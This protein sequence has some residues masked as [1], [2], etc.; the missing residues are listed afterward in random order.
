[1]LFKKIRKGNIEL[2]EYL[3]A[4]GVSPATSETK[5][6]RTALMIAAE[7]QQPEMIPI[8]VKVKKKIYLTLKV[9]L[10]KKTLAWM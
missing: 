2:L 9:D 1:M 10:E 3:V 6:G 8:L 5:D 7:H 4:K